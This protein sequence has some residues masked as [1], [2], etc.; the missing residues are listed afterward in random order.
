[1]KYDFLRAR[2][3]NEKPCSSLQLSQKPTELSWPWLQVYACMHKQSASQGTFLLIYIPKVLLLSL[4]ANTAL[5]GSP[6]IKSL[7][8]AFTSSTSIKKWKLLGKRIIKR[9]AGLLESKICKWF[10]RLLATNE[11]PC[12]Q[13]YIANASALKFKSGRDLCGLSRFCISIFNGV[14][15]KWVGF[16]R[17]QKRKALFSTQ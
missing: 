7:S 14:H 6:G 17:Q 2:F 15:I 4:F 9:R 5:I 3:V 1:M 13:I 8:E 10:L 16:W 11:A 12:S